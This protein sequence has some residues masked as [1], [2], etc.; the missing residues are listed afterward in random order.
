[1]LKSVIIYARVIAF[2]GTERL[3]LDEAMKHELSHIPM[4]LCEDSG[5]IW[6]RRITTKGMYDLS[7]S[8]EEVDVIIIQQ[9]FSAVKSRASTVKV[10]CDVILPW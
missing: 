5:E 1:M 4:S 7:T 3:Q 8:H 6:I 2:I 9:V 10:I